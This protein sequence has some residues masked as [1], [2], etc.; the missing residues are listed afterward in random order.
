MEPQPSAQDPEARVWGSA[1]ALIAIGF[2]AFVAVPAEVAPYSLVVVIPALL[3]ATLLGQ[4]GLVVGGVLGS[5]IPPAIFL[6]LARH[7]RKTGN[8]LPK[9]S[10]ITF[11][12]IAL[13][14]VALAGSGWS[15]TVQYTSVE[16]AKALVA[17]AVIPALVLA[18]LGF[19][20]RRQLTLRASL[21]LHWLGCAW[22]AWSAF[23]W[24]GELL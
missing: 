24:Y 18:M 8:L 13:S 16:R 6:A 11:A 15:L 23:P 19:T 17:Q 9:A 1:L 7:V 3:S 2:A 21:I 20:M 14:S 12:V 10:V 22:L 5:L 4:A